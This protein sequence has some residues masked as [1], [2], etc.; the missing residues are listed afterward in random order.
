STGGFF[1]TGLTL[2][3]DVKDVDKLG[4]TLSA[5]KQLLAKQVTPDART[6]VGE[7]DADGATIQYLRLGFDG[8]GIFLPAWAVV[9]KKLFIGLYPQVVEDAVRQAKAAKSLLDNPQFSSTRKQTGG[10]GPMFYLSGPEFVR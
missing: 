8:F 6:T 1:F 10:E 7:Y 9:D 2:V 4:R 5:L 3:V